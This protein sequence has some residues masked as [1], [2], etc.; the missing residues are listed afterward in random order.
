MRR[1]KH[2]GSR[3]LVALACPFELISSLSE[4]KSA[5][6]FFVP[7]SSLR[8]FASHHNLPPTT[9]KK[10]EK[11]MAATAAPIRPMLATGD[12][13]YTPVD[14]PLFA[15]IQR[16]PPSPVELFTGHGF[17]FPKTPPSAQYLQPSAASITLSSRWSSS[18]SSCTS[19]AQSSLASSP[20]S[21][22]LTSASGECSR[23][24]V[25]AHLSSSNSSRVIT[26]ADVQIR[27]TKNAGSTPGGPPLELVASE[28]HCSSASGSS[29]TKTDKA[30]ARSQLSSMLTRDDA[31]MMSC[32]SENGNYEDE[33]ED[34]R[35]GKRTREEQE[36]WANLILKPLQVS[37][38]PKGPRR[39]RS[40]PGKE[41]DTM[42][43]D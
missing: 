12:S 27:R 36:R 31:E 13:C 8:G 22:P 2:H 7:A 18:S 1:I 38:P 9:T 25:A 10:E 37:P 41:S 17:P 39:L 5:R 23:P 28:L 26:P 14:S 24:H 42:D 20:W 43:E 6:L 11:K 4:P 40:S 32:K 29:I 16:V 34:E 21:P 3:M 19:S 15:S 30:A 33:D 35:F